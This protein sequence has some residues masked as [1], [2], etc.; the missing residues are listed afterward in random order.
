MRN[1]QL[2]VF[3]AV[4]PIAVSASLTAQDVASVRPENSP[5]Q[6]DPA[7]VQV[8]GKV[9]PP[10]L[11]RQKDPKYPEAALKA[12]VSGTVLLRVVVD[13]NGTPGKVEVSKG[14]GDSPGDDL[15]L[16]QS[17]ID[18][19]RQ[20]RFSPAT[21]GGQPVAVIVTVQVAFRAP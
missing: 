2:F 9:K 5:Q 12:G 17:A 4:L 14:I 10:K 13:R 19:V 3:F 8:G 18:A 20:W 15:G 7:A 6:Q 21:K 16:N 1:S 11:L